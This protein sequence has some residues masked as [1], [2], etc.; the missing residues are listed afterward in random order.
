MLFAHDLKT[1]AEQAVQDVITATRI[2]D[3]FKAPQQN[4]AHGKDY[5]S[6]PLEYVRLN[7]VVFYLLN[8]RRFFTR[9]TEQMKE[10][11]QWYKTTVEVRGPFF[12]SRK[13]MIWCVTAS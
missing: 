2:V 3:E 12:D 9:V 5:A 13:L 11:L 4:A 7:H 6:F 8:L 10:K 1:K